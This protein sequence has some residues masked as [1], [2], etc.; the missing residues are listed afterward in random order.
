MI[1][2]KNKAFFNTLLVLSPLQFI[3]YYFFP[4]KYYQSR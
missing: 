4:T 1:K 2:G 3:D